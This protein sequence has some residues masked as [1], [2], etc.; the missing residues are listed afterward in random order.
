M[1][2]ECLSKNDSRSMPS[3]H[4]PIW[5]RDWL[6]KTGNYKLSCDRSRDF[7]IFRSGWHMTVRKSCH[8][9]TDIHDWMI[10]LLEIRSF[11]LMLCTRL[12]SIVTILR[13]MHQ[14]LVIIA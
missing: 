10:G 9:H 5:G 12:L 2:W 7:V 13:T 4:L 6:W 8:L 1:N 3:W 11:L 14:P